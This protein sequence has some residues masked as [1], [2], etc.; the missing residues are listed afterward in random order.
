M[1]PCKI[2]FSDGSQPVVVEDGEFWS[3]GGDNDCDIYITGLL[4]GIFKIE[5][6]DGVYLPPIL[7]APFEYVEQIQDSIFLIN[8]IAKITCFMDPDPSLLFTLSV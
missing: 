8:D 2:E 5:S 1:S 3:T 7:L 4:G 6:P